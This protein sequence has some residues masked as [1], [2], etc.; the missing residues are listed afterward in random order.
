MIIIVDRRHV[1]CPNIRTLPA[2]RNWETSNGGRTAISL[3]RNYLCSG[4]GLHLISI[5]TFWFWFSL[6][7]WWMRMIWS[8]CATNFSND[9]RVFF[10]GPW[11]NAPRSEK[12]SISDRHQTA[13]MMQMKRR[14]EQFIYLF[15]AF[16][17]FHS[18]VL[19]LSRSLAYSIFIY[20]CTLSRILQKKLHEMQKVIRCF[21][22]WLFCLVWYIAIRTYR[23]ALRESVVF[24]NQR[25]TFHFKLNLRVDYTL[26]T[27]KIPTRHRDITFRHL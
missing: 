5:D 22:S 3:R 8:F 1:L 17:W 20:D 14:R 2:P 24:K 25:Q 23:C 9:P 12:G 6:H 10:I 16:T 4:I 18:I 19:S 13:A 7:I 15:I 27:L 11:I 26:I 21:F